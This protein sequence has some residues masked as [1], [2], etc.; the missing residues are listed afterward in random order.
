[1]SSIG[2]APLLLFLAFVIP[3]PVQ[4]GKS[5]MGLPDLCLF[6]RWTGH[7]C[8]GCGITRSVVCLA[9]G[10]IAEALR[11]HPL[12]PIAFG[13]LVAATLQR[14]PLP[15]RLRPSARFWTPR[16]QTLC[17]G[18]LVILLLGIWAARL[19]GWLPSPP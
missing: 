17:Y 15:D 12:A 19:A 4:G 2:I 5:L 11:F 1:M 6:H 7:P 18:G 14:L 13:F 8:P 10:H 16:V 3:L 9:H